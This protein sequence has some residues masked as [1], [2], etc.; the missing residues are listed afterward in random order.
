[1][2]SLFQSP[3]MGPLMMLLAVL[4]IALFVLVKPAGAQNIV[5]E[6]TLVVGIDFP[7]EV[8]VDQEFTVQVSLSNPSLVGRE[9]SGQ[10]WIGGEMWGGTNYPMTSSAGTNLSWIE[11]NT[12][13]SKKGCTHW[14]KGFISPGGEANFTVQT[15]SGKEVGEEQ[16]FHM[17]LMDQN[18]EPFSISVNLAVTK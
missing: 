15:S 7:T 17:V 14:W 13:V 18:H 9:F 5:G 10:I 1:M 8:K 16:F 6:E 3:V 11:C 2:R 4:G 12:P